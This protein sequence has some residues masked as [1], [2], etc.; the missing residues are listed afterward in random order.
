L[1]ELLSTGQD[2]NCWCGSCDK[3]WALNRAERTDVQRDWDTD[4]VAE[5]RVNPASTFEA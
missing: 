4:A 2:I 5:L 3:H 1:T